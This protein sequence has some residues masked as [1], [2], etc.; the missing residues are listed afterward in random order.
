MKSKNIII[1]IS[2]NNFEIDYDFVY[3]FYE[4]NETL[5]VDDFIDNSQSPYQ[6]SKYIKIDLSFTN[7]L[8]VRPNSNKSQIDIEF[9]EG[10]SN[11]KSLTSEERKLFNTIDNIDNHIYFN[12]D[13]KQSMYSEKDSFGKTSSYFNVSKDDLKEKYSDS[14]VVYFNKNYKEK[15]VKSKNSTKLIQNKN[16]D[17]LLSYEKLFDL[18]KID[19]NVNNSY[20]N[21]IP[22]IDS[23]VFSFSEYND[24]DN[25][26]RTRKVFL[27]I[28]CDKYEKINE[29]YELKSSSFS[30]DKENI[31][32]EG[33]V[34]FNKTIID[35]GIKYGKIYKYVFYPVYFYSRI[36]NNT[37]LY[38]SNYLLCDVPSITE[39]INCI[40]KIRPPYV[41]NLRGKYYENRQSLRLYWSMPAEKQRDIKGFQIFKRNKLKEP[42]KLVKQIESHKKTDFY[43]RNENIP[44]QY[45]EINENVLVTEFFDDTFKPT[46]VTIYAICSIDAHGLV[47]NYSEQIAFTYDYLNKETLAD[48]VSTSG[49]PIFYPNIMIPR[50]TIFFD[51][52]DKIATITPTASNKKKFTLMFTP[53][54]LYH[55]YEN[56][57]SNNVETLFKDEYEFSIFRLNNRSVYEDKFNVEYNNQE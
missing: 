56:S 1:D 43:T 28:L 46:E 57:G 16:V 22:N 6:K 19:E 12:E 14:N 55:N 18:N 50:K 20:I 52:D 54:C 27:G 8:D 25:N 45:I 17:N 44:L 21:F 4:E 36:D 35:I 26:L 32:T 33:R 39:D 37:G 7:I 41:G 10:I 15:I 2:A 48:L 3:N 5:T 13:I 31:I 30:F 29:A 9:F 49:A 47:S 11:N 42:F 38:L 40:E 34:K 51:N 53:D 24:E 23:N